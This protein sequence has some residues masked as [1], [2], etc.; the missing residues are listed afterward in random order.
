M[1]VELLPVVRQ[2]LVTQPCR[3]ALRTEQSREQMRLGATEP[4]TLPQ[5][6]RGRQRHT[7]ILR[8]PGVTDVVPHEPERDLRK[9][10]VFWSALAQPGRPAVPLPGACGR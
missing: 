3:N 2:P 9:V 10:R 6:I 8:I 4:N 1:D 7:R 5:D